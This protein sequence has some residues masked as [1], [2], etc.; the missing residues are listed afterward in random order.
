MLI[1]HE[2][3]FPIRSR[4]AKPKKIISSFGMCMQCFCCIF[5]FLFLGGWYW[6]LNSRPHA[7]WPGAGLDHEPSSFIPAQE[8]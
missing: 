5:H 7:C 8:V 2:S 6:G 4:E 1:L 3:Y